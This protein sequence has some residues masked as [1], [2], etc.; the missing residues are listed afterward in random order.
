MDCCFSGID[1]IIHTLDL[2]RSLIIKVIGVL[3]LSLSEY[4]Y[5]INFDVLL[6]V[7]NEYVLASPGQITRNYSIDT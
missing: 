4:S 5:R 7:D 2:F 6:L 1:P 3:G